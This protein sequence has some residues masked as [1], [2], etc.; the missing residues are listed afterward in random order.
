MPSQWKTPC[1]AFHL[2]QNGTSDLPDFGS[3]V[4]I[5]NDSIEAWNLPEKSSLHAHYAGLTNEYRIGFN[6]Y[7]VQNANIIVFRDDNWSESRAIMALTT[8]TQNRKT[9][10]IFDADIEINTQH[11]KFGIVNADSPHVV[12]L[13]NTLTHELG[14]A[15]GLAHSDVA[16]ATMFPYSGTGD[17]SL[18]SLDDD[19][20]D[21]IASI[22]PHSE[23]T[24]QFD[25]RFFEAPPFAMDERPPASDSCS[26]APYAHHRSPF[27]AFFIALSAIFLSI[28][29]KKFHHI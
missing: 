1:V 18:V 23:L 16:S 6:P 5:V 26:A 14:H 28:F 10:E 13:Q 21:A 15:F 12:D 3:V 24:C 7:T 8:I 11:Y 9:G 22:Y 25:D 29:R 17:T 20:V 27:F 19:D 2:N 4:K